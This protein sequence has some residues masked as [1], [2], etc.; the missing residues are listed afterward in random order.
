MS[1]AFL[2]SFA[3]ILSNE[4]TDI[5][6][7]EGLAEFWG[8]HPDVWFSHAVMSANAWTMIT[9]PYTNTAATNI[10]LLLHYDQ[11]YRHPAPPSEP[12]LAA[13][14]ERERPVAFRFATC[15]AF[16]ILHEQWSQ[17]A[18]WERV[19][20]LLAIRHNP[21][22]ALKEF[23]L[24]KA[25]SLAEESPN[26]SLYVRF[27]QASVWDVHSFK[28]RTVGYPVE[29]ATS[30]A[31]QTTQ[32]IQT[33]PQ[34]PPLYQHLL[35]TPSSHTTTTPPT[36]ETLFGIFKKA[37][38]PLPGQR[39]AVSI[40]GGVDS[41]VAA[42]IAARVA[43]HIGR[44]LLL[45]HV[46]YGNRAEECP[47]ECELLR[48]Y[49]HRLGVPLYIRHITEMQRVRHT[50]L[51][52]VYEAVT[53]RIRF[54]FYR[55][56]DCPIILGHNLDDCYE[57]VFSNLSKRIHF[58]NLFGMSV[59]GSEEGVTIVRPLLATPKQEILAFADHVAKVPHL[60]DSTPA[61]SRR[62]Q[63]RDRL[64]PAI[65]G[66]DPAILTGL[67]AFVEHTTALEDQWSLAFKRWIAVVQQSE[68]IREGVWQL[69]RADEFLTTNWEREDFWI[70]VWQHLT[71]LGWPRPSNKSFRN[72][73]AA[74]KR[75]EGVCVLH[76]SIRARFAPSSVT[77]TWTR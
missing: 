1:R 58:G 71:A 63:M 68:A 16:R 29:P 64:I 61:W 60:Y 8:T 59:H 57:N 9:Q 21:N 65:A 34:S 54:A 74:L 32:T 40:S 19:F 49:A 75:T 15:L 50:E 73:V 23:A 70:R 13:I 2:Q 6:L 36:T 12:C 52:A 30:P 17:L 22:L 18:A 76:Q 35:Q 66:F 26:E 56:F 62:G 47:L 37:L 20:V 27:L 33:I 10:T 31:I 42:Y 69:S 51:R 55:H 7:L 53:R 48:D 5:V 41:M 25:L 39:F 46:N 77:I 72:L 43:K 14:L 38:E 44:E 45:L 4:P 67:R 24:R 28:E 3:P 11:I